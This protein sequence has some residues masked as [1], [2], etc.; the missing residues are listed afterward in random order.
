MNNYYLGI[1]V[2]KGYSDFVLLNQ[3]KHPIGKAFQLD[4]TFEGHHQLHVFLSEFLKENPNARIHAA[5]ESTGG[6]ENNW[7][8][9]LTMFQTGFNTYD[10]DAKKS[11]SDTK[12]L[13]ARVNPFGVYMNSKAD[14]KRIKT[15]NISA[16]SIAE[17]LIAHS[18]KVAYQT[19]D[20]FASVRRQ[21][22]LLKLLVKQKA[23]LINQLQ[24]LLYTA[25]TELVPRCQNGMR[26][27]ILRV[28]KN[29]PTARQLAKAKVESLSKIPYVTQPVAEKL[30][31]QAKTSVS[32]SVDAITAETVQYLVSE[33]LAKWKIINSLKLRLNANCSLPEVKLLTSFSGIGAYSA[34]G[35]LIE[36]GSVSRFAGVKQ[37]ACYFGVHPV[38]SQSGDKTGQFRM[39]KKG[40]REPRQILFNVARFAIVHNPLMK[41]IYAEH[42]KNGKPK[43]AALG[44]LMHKILRIVYGMLKNNRPFDPEID[45]RNRAQKQQNTPDTVANKKLKLSPL[46]LNAPVSRRQNKLRKEQEMTQKE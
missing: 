41:E 40:R 8:N 3:K 44:A 5:V 39:S 36:I 45:R 16:I 7:F 10:T 1:D 9:V 11:E 15:D 38:F 32:S 21:W 20:Y 29:Y 34:I 19:E 22:T 42:L 46:N 4:D 24:S 25:N 37:L 35:L 31:H 14:L 17:Y 2:S 6:Y 28:L 27:W 18:E 26:L 30:I 43:M 23:Q 33:I 12:L 13:V